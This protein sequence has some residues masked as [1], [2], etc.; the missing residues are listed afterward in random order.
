MRTFVDREFCARD[1]LLEKE[2]RKPDCE[3]V[4]NEGEGGVRTPVGITL[5]SGIDFDSNLRRNLSRSDSAIDGCRRI[6]GCCLLGALGSL[7][8]ITSS[9]RC[10]GA[11]K[12]SALRVFGYLKETLNDDDQSPIERGCS[13]RATS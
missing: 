11:L 2:L 7:R 6:S 9:R 5:K 10:S 13:R 12:S 1:W 8:L 4:D 3:T